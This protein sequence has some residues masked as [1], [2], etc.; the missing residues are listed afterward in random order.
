[1]KQF[2]RLTSR[3]LWLII[4]TILLT[5]WL[6]IIDKVTEGTWQV[7][8]MAFGGAYICTNTYQKFLEIAYHE[9]DAKDS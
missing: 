3:R 2:E 7:V 1:M 9:K 8:V 6:L 4:G 5:T